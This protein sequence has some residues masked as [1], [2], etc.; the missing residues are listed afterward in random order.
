RSRDWAMGRSSSTWCARSATA[1]ATVLITRGSA[2]SP[3]D[4]A[5]T[6]TPGTPAA[7]ARPPVG[8]ARPLRVLFCVDQSH[9]GG[10]EMNAVRTAERFDP[11]RVQLEVLC[12]R[13]EGPLL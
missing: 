11:A 8:R 9:V 5:V 2:G 10:T 1:P 13:A 3:G 4:P 12:L 7:P 6:A